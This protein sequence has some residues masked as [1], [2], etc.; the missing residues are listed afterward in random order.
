MS[1]DLGRNWC[2]PDVMC[3]GLTSETLLSTEAATEIFIPKII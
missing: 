1:H 3:I 2:K